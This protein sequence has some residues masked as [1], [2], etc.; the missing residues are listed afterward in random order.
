MEAQ[1]A[2]HHHR[3]LF[4]LHRD[5][6][7]DRLAADVLDV[8]TLEDEDEGERE[9]AAMNLSGRAAPSLWEERA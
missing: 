3:D 8:L 5:H 6:G 2:K 1:V 4:H 7:I 9:V